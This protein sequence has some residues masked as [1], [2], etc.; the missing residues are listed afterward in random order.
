MDNIYTG[1]LE[2]YDPKAGF[3]VNIK[4]WILTDC[5]KGSLADFITDQRQTPAYNHRT[6]P[7]VKVFFDQDG[8]SNLPIN[9]D[10]INDVVDKL[11][12]DD[13]SIIKT[14][15]MSEIEDIAIEIIGQSRQTPLILTRMDLV[16]AFSTYAEVIT[17]RGY[18]VTDTPEFREAFEAAYPKIHTMLADP[19]LDDMTPIKFVDSDC[20]LMSKVIVDIVDAYVRTTHPEYDAFCPLIYNFINTPYDVRGGRRVIINGDWDN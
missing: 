15:T 13:P 18:I 1:I 8:T 3:P 5:F 9:E 19:E 17:T 20:E 7:L 16:E 6:F 10:T 4:N 2:S 12:H 11:V 14:H